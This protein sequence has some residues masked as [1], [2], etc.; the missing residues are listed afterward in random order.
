MSDM[1]LALFATGSLVVSIIIG[2]LLP[3][4]KPD[5]NSIPVIDPRR[6]D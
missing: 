5:E 3:V 1:A 2:L 6:K 4:E